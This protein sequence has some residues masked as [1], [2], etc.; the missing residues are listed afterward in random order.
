MEWHISGIDLEIACQPDGTV[1]ISFED[2]FGE[3]YEGTATEDMAQLKQFIGRLPG[4]RH[5]AG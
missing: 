2:R 1:E 3:E 5:R 4:S